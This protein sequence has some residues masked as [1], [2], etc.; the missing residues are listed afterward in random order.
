MINHMVIKLSSIVF[1]RQL[2]PPSRSERMFLSELQTVFREL[3]TLDTAIALPS[4]SAWL[5]NMDRLRKLVL[6]QNPREFLRWD[7]VSSTMFITYA[8]Y[9]SRELKYLRSQ[10]D[11]N[12]RW[13]SAIKESLVGYPI[14][15]I[16]YPASSGNLIHHAY[17][18]AQ[19][20]EKTRAQ[21]HEIDFVLEY[22]GGYGSMC[23]L[24][25]N[26][27]FRGKYVIFDL[28]S[29]SAL[30]IYYL[31]TLGLPVQP[32]TGLK[33]R[34]GIVCVS[35][36]SILESILVDCANENKLFIATW[37][38][39]ETPSSVRDTILSLVSDF[40]SFL[41]AY[42][43]RFGEVNNL[44]YFDRW[45]ETVKNVFW[46]NWQIEHIPGNYYLIGKVAPSSRS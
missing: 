7:I 15:Y 37:S 29:F 19:F 32:I 28:P 31:K 14:A 34:T 46:H 20:E 8:S 35:D 41:I 1:D 17:H 3:P 26:L 23:R 40:Q 10:S 13:R 11:W 24:F 22:G 9:I 43:D 18:V 12:T 2:P 36:N 33:S 25:Y 4:E 30:Q 42:Q 21:V 6:N 5:S 39:S 38:M 27:G 44:G 45:K 16:F